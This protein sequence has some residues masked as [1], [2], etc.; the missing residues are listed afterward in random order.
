[1]SSTNEKIEAWRHSLASI[2]WKERLTWLSGK[3]MQS[4]FSTSFS[5]EDQVITHLIADQA[6][7]ITI[8]TLDTGRLFEQ[9]RS[10]Q[11]ETTDRYGITIRTMHPDP[12]V[13]ENY[14]S[15]HGINGFYQ[16]VEKRKLCCF[17]RKVEPLTRALEGI[18]V[19]V[20]GVRREHSENRSE[21][22]VV[23]WDEA[24][25]VIKFYPLIDVSQ[26][27][28]EHFTVRE[29]IPM[30]PLYDQGYTS[31]GCAPCTRPT[32]PGEH[33]RAGRWWW[34]Q[35]DGELQAQECGL[36]MVDGKLVRASTTE[37]GSHA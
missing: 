28:I 24:H 6:L 4:T 36:H 31:I 16:S 9:T 19:W 20:S 10:L 7:P 1:M 11:Q 30:N 13:L 8:F 35:E 2:D 23:E 34:E 26:E 22:P 27:E 25:N 37:E 17:I 14:V 15:S 32:Q 12:L 21:M 5:L 18:D 3:N 29:N 33:P